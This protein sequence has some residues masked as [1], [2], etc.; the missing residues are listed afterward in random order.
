M[1]VLSITQSLIRLHHFPLQVWRSGGNQ[2]LYSPKSQLC[3]LEGTA[4]DLTYKGC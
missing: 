2:L 4:I 3:Y 1:L